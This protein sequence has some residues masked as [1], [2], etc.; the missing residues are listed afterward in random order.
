VASAAGPA[1]TL[2]GRAIASVARGDHGPPVLLLHGF[3]ADRMSWALQQAGLA[4]FAATMAIDLPAHGESGN[5]AGDGS[6]AH[7]TNV[8]AGFL[9]S[10]SMA[11]AH[12]VGHSLGGAIAVDLAHRSPDR[13]ASL[14]LIAPAGLGRAIDH[15]FL[16]DFLSI[17]SVDQAQRVLARL[18]A[19]PRLISRQMAARVLDRVSQP[20]ARDGLRKIAAALA[21]VAHGLAPAIASISRSSLPRIV[22]WG[23]EDRIN[24]IDADRV[25]S[26]AKNLTLLPATGHL[27]QVETA[28]Q[29]DTLL[30][31][32]YR[33]LGLT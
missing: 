33:E 21:D 13:V 18:V 31:S 22:V 28:A 26:F 2:A 11:A 6:I 9:Q 14:V 27:P 17:E 25:T 7:L 3:G 20:G 4:Q 8:V 29:V 23:E 5:D 19:R 10:R 15:E 32:F 16:A 12:V 30:R 1:V 24:P